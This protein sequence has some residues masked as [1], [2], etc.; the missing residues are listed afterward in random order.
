MMSVLLSLFVPV[1]YLYLAPTF[2][3][4][5]SLAPPNMRAT[6]CAVFLFG[7]N[8][9]NLAVAPQLIGFGSDLLAAH[10][11]LGNQSL[12][13]MLAAMAFTGFWSA[14]HFWRV[15]RTFRGDLE[16]AAIVP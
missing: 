9:A 13:W 1:A 16:R 10:S 2:G 14:Y 4:I 3:W 15:A 11:R 8:I 6:F 7:S 5:Q 12:R